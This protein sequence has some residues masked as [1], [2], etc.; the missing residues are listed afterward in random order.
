MRRKCGT[1]E[2]NWYNFLGLER[3]PKYCL[4]D[5]S[6]LLPIFCKD[7]DVIRDTKLHSG[8]ATLVLLRRIISET[9]H[10]Y[11][12]WENDYKGDLDDFASRLSD[13]LK[14]SHMAFRL[15]R[16]DHKMNTR[17][18]KM[19]RNKTHGGLSKVD[20]SL[21]CAAMARRDMDVVTGD[22]SLIGSIRNENPKARRRIYS[23]LDNHNKR[24]W[25]TMG[26]IK[27][28]IVK[29]VAMDATVDCQY[30]ASHTEFLIGGKVVVSIQ[31]PQGEKGRVDLSRQIYDTHA[32]AEL[33]KKKI[34]RVFSEW[35]PKRGGRGPLRE[36]DLYKRNRDDT[37]DWADDAE[38]RSSRKRKR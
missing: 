34:L 12:K 1:M 21:L 25:D 15:S 37:Y 33:I 9:L 17:L 35:K 11:K 7:T 13:Q 26:F 18:D 32:D 23:V 2:L 31:H 4:V 27:H 38:G 8:G 16:F 19:I 36:K 20:Y 30:M 5:T 29:N 24:R 28:N 10:V 3:G 6:A 22:K 14:S